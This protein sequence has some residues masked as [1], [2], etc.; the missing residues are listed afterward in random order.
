MSYDV[1]ESRPATSS[2]PFDHITRSV[3]VFSDAPRPA[4]PRIRRFF[5]PRAGIDE[6][7]V[8]GSAH[9]GLVPYWAERLGRNEFT[10]LQA[11]ART[12][13]LH[14]RVEGDR[15]LLGGECHTVIVGQFQL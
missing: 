14:C 1:A 7:P 2:E 15:V 9:C 3:D 12:G 6:D 10:A 5:A 8:T 11:S 4:D 13:I